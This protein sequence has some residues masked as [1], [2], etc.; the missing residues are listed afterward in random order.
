MNSPDEYVVAVCLFI[1]DVVIWGV[2]VPVL[3]V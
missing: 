3:G 2:F 1:C